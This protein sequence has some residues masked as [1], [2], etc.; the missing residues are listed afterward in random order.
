MYQEQLIAPLFS[1]A[2]NRDSDPAP[3]GYLALGGLPPLNISEDYSSTP[4]QILTIEGLETPNEL[5]FY[6][7]QPDGYI[8][9]N[10][11]TVCVFSILHFLVASD[12][13]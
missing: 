7:I 1:L 5:T 9:G 12:L 13:T 3:S 10:Q 6:T 11:T 8:Y 4:I 2:L